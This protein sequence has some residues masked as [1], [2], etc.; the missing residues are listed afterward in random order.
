MTHVV[1]GDL[2]TCPQHRDVT[3][4]RVAQ[5]GC[6]L[7]TGPAKAWAAWRYLTVPHALGEKSL[8]GL[9]CFRGES[10]SLTLCTRA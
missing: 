10:V 6:L 9:F 8:A 3:A 1:E 2:S 4:G 7:T 5:L